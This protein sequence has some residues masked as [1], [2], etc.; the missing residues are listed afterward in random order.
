MLLAGYKGRKKK[1]RSSYI[2]TS[3]FVEGILCK[4]IAL[5]V[6]DVLGCSPKNLELVG[7]VVSVYGIQ[8]NKFYF[9]SPL[10]I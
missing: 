5:L 6:M 1:R 9:I 2:T 4:F 7:T 10:V 8:V 3:K